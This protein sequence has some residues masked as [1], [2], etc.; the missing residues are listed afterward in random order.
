METLFHSKKKR[1]KKKRIRNLVLSEFRYFAL[2][3]SSSPVE[4]AA[5]QKMY[6]IAYPST[7]KNLE[8]ICGFLVTIQSGR[9]CYRLE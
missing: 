8:M 2:V 6:V 3:N 5:F 1:G 4:N 9:E 7:G